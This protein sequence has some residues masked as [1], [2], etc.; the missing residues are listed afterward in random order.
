[1]ATDT[2][3]NENNFKLNKNIVDFIQNE[4][5]FPTMMAVQKASI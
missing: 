3:W 4:L 2:K 1:M 5:K